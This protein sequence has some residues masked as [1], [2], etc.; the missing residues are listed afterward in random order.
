MIICNKNI[1]WW[2]QVY[3]EL[4][5]YGEKIKFRKRS[6]HLLMNITLIDNFW[7]SH[8]GILHLNTQNNNRGH[9]VRLF[10]SSNIVLLYLG[11]WLEKIMVLWLCSTFWVHFTMLAPNSKHALHPRE[12]PRYP[13]LELTTCLTGC[14]NNG[15][16]LAFTAVSRS[17][18]QATWHEGSY[19]HGFT[20]TS[21]KHGK[22][23]MYSFSHCGSIDHHALQP[24][25][26]YI[27]VF[28]WLTNW[29]FRILGL[30]IPQNS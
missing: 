6:S 19:L 18:N 26:N 1:W 28:S 8:L 5:E 3:N 11:I 20:S 7:G 23:E 4:Q 15:H 10:N 13:H 16:G 29:H 25:D 17:S 22:K 21:W 14:A 30:V 9:H 27:F 2:H 24:L 12:L